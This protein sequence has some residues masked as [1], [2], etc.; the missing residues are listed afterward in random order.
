M[1]EQ[2]NPVTDIQDPLGLRHLPP[3]ESQE[4]GWPAIKAALAEEAAG[5]RTR[6]VR[7]VMLATAASAVLAIVAVLN[8]PGPVP[9]ESNNAVATIEPSAASVEQEQT[10]KQLIAMSQ[11][12]E[13]QLRGLRDGSGSM[14]ASSAVYVAEL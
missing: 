3:L 5:R 2:T 14:P 9:T 13:Q 4:D 1:N 12:L 11:N 10:L 7:M 6:R 8:G